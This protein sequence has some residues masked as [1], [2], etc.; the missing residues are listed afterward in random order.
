MTS[1]QH[2]VGDRGVNPYRLKINDHNG[3]LFDTHTYG[4]PLKS[5][6]FQSLFAEQTVY[7]E[8]GSGSGAHLIERA[9]RD[10]SASWVGIERRFKRAVRTIEKATEAG[11]DQ[12]FVARADVQDVLPVVP[13]N[14]LDGIYLLFP[15]PWP[16]PRHWKNRFF[17]S[18][19]LKRLA[20]I[21]KKEGFFY[22]KT[23]HRDYYQWAMKELQSQSV[24][25]VLRHCADIY[26]ERNP[27][28]EI[29]SE[30]ENLFLSK[31][32]PVAE[33]MLQKVGF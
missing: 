7:L 26:K 6:T 12:V 10:P 3:R 24:F 23:D 14:S 1:E 21:I 9:R 19:N 20:P 2:I 29:R 32:E 5:K 27:E 30:F 4:R 15:D 25:K 18:D 33:I 8:I 13:E 16:K 22:F 28:K 31:N 11:V 17:S